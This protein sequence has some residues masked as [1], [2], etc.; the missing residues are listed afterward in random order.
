MRSATGTASLRPRLNLRM[1]VVLL[2]ILATSVF[3][4]LKLIEPDHTHVQTPPKTLSHEEEGPVEPRPGEEAVAT[5]EDGGRVTAHVV[6]AVAKPGIVLL[7]EGARVFEAV[8]KAGGLSAEAAPDSV[9]LAEKIQDG[10]QIRILTKKEAK[11]APAS[12][13]GQRPGNQ[14]A[15]TPPDGSQSAAGDGVKV[16]V[17]T[18]DAAGLEQLPGVGPATAAKII[19]HREQFGPFASPEELT[20]V[21]GIGPA[22]VEK[23]RDQL[24]F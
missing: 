6:G 5:E 2:A 15:S 13:P 21:R 4:F 8:E 1:G 11:Q 23:F 24:E 19:S 16:N 20:A 7:A 3:V 14:T 10:A 17:N 9:N 22:T 12:P 18:A